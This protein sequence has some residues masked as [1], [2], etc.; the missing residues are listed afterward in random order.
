M[1]RF[2][3]IL[4]A[5]V[6]LLSVGR[7]EASDSAS[8]DFFAMDTYMTVLANGENAEEAVLA[9]EEEVNRL[10]AA[11]STGQESSEIAGINRSGVGKLSSDGCALLEKALE[12]YEESG[13]LFDITIYP[14]MDLW[15]FTSGEYHVPEEKELSEALSLVDA[16]KIR[17]DEE[18]G[19]VFFEEPEMKMDFGGIAKGYTSA[20]LMDLFRDKGITS[21]LVDLGGNVQAL[22]TKPDGSEWRIG[23]RD[24]ED[25][26]GMLGILS[27]S[28]LAVITSGGYERYFEENGETYHHIIDPRTGYPAESGLLSV[29][30]VS[31]DG[32]LADG[33]STFLFIAGR[34]QA[35]EFWRTHKEWFEMILV[36]EDRSILLTEGLTERFT[37]DYAFSVIS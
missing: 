33:L 36:L 17:Y 9:A 29:T 5:A 14:V 34:E 8:R 20:R 32:T 28:D 4:C 12:L 18:S 21:A 6:L 30:I 10:D 2:T 13:S 27:I 24:P 31:P 35:E 1:K 37:S 23:I 3:G 11:L 7:V 26:N 25:E 22:G 16:S 19:E 15:G